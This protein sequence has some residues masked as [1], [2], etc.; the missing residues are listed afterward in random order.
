V[1]QVDPDNDA[2]PAPMCGRMPDAAIIKAISSAD[3]QTVCR[4]MRMLDGVRVKDIRNFS[5]AALVLNHEGYKG[6][7][8]EITEQLVEI[9]R[10]RGLYDKPD[11]W[12]ANLDIIV[13]M[14][15]AFNGVVTPIDAI[16]FLR[17]AGKAGKTM[18]DDSFKTMLLVLMEQ[19]RQSD[20]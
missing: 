20:N 3:A 1:A 19:K 14:Y 9:V 6:S 8:D 7:Y 18:S 11:R 16:E 5:K 15:E 12:Y 13:R 2:T 10:L 4:A 17:G